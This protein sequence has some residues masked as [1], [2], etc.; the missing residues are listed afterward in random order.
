[1]YIIQ[2]IIIIIW[3]V[4]L[5]PLNMVFILPHRRGRTKL[6]PN[7]FRP[8]GPVIAKHPNN[9][10]RLQGAVLQTSHIHNPIYYSDPIKVREDIYLV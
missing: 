8:S 2:F 4:I 7:P 10:R 5:E 1:M 3:P 6:A 9:P